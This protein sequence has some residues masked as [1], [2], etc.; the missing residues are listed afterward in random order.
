MLDEPIHSQPAPG[1]P[2]TDLSPLARYVLAT[3]PAFLLA[4]VLPVFIG[5]A[6]AWQDGITLSLSLLLFSLFAVILVHAGANVLNDY[7]DARNGTDLQNKDYLYPYTGGSRFI[8][9]GVLSVTQTRDYGLLL[10]VGGIL[11][12]LWLISVSGPALLGIGMLG[13]LLAWGYSGPPLDLN[14][15]G[16]G[17]LSILICFGILIVSGSD[18]V[19]RGELAIQPLLLAIPYGLLCAALLYI[20]QFPDRL[21]DA[22]AG[23]HHWVVRLGPARARWGYLLLVLLAHAWVCLLI[24]TG[25]GSPWLGLALLSAP[26]SLLA[27]SG[28]IRHAATPIHLRPAIRLTLLAM[29]AHALLLSLGLLLAGMR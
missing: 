19:Q 28:L 27:A 15:R 21:A 22:A 16:L 29:T 9:N 23:K 14:R 1:E 12:G 8:Q 18:Y 10:L 3:R 17:E 26:L 20:N 4:A 11:P 13:I 7:Y 2:R 6:S 24:L 25:I 5:T